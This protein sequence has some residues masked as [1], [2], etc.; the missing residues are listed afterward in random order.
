VRR[1]WDPH[2]IRLDEGKSSEWYA[3]EFRQRFLDAVRARLPDRSTKL[4]VH[5]SGGFDSAA[6]TAAVHHWNSQANLR[7]EPWAFV[8][9]ARHPAADEQRYVHAVLGRFP[10]PVMQTESAEFWAFRPAPLLRQWQ[11]EPYAAPYAA[12][13]VA[14]LAAARELGIGV[15]VSG[16]GGDEVG[17]SSFYLLDLLLRGKLNRFWPEL[18][19]RARGKGQNTLTLLAELLNYSKGCFRSRR[20][21]VA[22]RKPVWLHPNLARRLETSHPIRHRRPL[23][24]NPARDDVLNR[25]RYCWIEPQ[26]SCSI[27]LY[28]HFGV[29]VRHPFLDRRVF[30]WALAVPPF[31]LGEVGLLKAPMRRAFME[32]LPREIAYRSD[33]S[34][35]LH[36]WD[37]GVRVRERERIL[38]MLDRSIAA[39]LR[40]IDAR[41]LKSEYVR[42]CRGA[43]IDRRK[44]WNAL[45]LEDWLGSGESNQREPWNGDSTHS[46]AV[47]T[48]S[49][50]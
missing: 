43:A 20:D 27:A 9:T 7:L 40:L 8:N 25:M 30:E 12:R 31:R 6:V 24:L 19:A 38:K 48:A 22:N 44:L 50:D 37:L 34:N 39:D 21:C 46:A 42:Y 2:G 29:E 36:Y 45:T 17:G 14:E 32:M 35:Y 5:V 26:L 18:R 33:K 10:M 49:A 23:H 1:Y 47:A 41:K 4:G 16:T 13:L 3:L 15:I 28:N 11:D